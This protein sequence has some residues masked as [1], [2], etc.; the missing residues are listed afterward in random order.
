MTGV[1]TGIVIANAKAKQMDRMTGDERMTGIGKGNA[2]AKQIDR[3][4]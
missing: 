3:M 4:T 1:T 2:K